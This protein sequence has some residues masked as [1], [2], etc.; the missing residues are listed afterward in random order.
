MALLNPSAAGG[1]GDGKGDTDGETDGKTDGV[2]HGDGKELIQMA[3]RDEMS[4]L[5]KR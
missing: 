1:R 4:E 3:E 2:G 5:T